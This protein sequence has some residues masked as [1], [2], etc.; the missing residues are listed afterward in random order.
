LSTYLLKRDGGSYYFRRAIPANLR[1][2]IDGRREWVK[3]LGTKSRTEAKQRIPQ[4]VIETDRELNR[5]V[6]MLNGR[7]CSDTE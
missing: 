2:F 7:A 1:P 3:S 4:L 5:A 6:A